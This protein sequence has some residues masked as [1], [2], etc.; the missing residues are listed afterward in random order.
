[1]N[2]RELRK[3]LLKLGIS[4]NLKGYHYIIKAVEIIKKQKIHTNMTTI[5]NMIAKEE[6]NTYSG[7]ERSIRH[8]LQK[9]WEHGMMKKIY[10]ETPDNSAFIYDLYFNFDIIKD[11]IIK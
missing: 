8:S 2:N 9:S 7:V 5:Y 4:S 10:N 1:M 6:E 11:G 3:A